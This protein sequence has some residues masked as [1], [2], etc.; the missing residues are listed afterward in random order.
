MI[1]SSIVSF[2]SSDINACR[3]PPVVE[4]LYDRQHMS[5]YRFLAIFD[6]V[7]KFYKPAVQ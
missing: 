1:I 4:Q 3:L 7:D 2:L 6:A 5:H